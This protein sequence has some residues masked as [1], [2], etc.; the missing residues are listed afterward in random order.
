[1]I[2]GDLD[3]ISKLL[4]SYGSQLEWAH[5]GGRI[6]ADHLRDVTR[7]C[8][9]ARFQLYVRE[10]EALV[11]A[12]SLVA[13]QLENIGVSLTAGDGVYGMNQ[14][15]AGWDR[16]VNLRQLQLWDCS[17]DHVQAAMATPK[18]NLE[19]VSIYLRTNDDDK[20]KAMCC[21]LYTS[22]S[23]RDA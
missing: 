4:V 13:G 15:T 9:K 3:A 10:M 16:C 23:P 7:A 2:G 1:M 19:V 12:L 20:K 11:P 17:V 21:L 6:T 22:P 8:T 18:L 5:L 14:V